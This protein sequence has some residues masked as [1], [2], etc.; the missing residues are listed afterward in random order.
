[1]GVEPDH[2]EPRGDSLRRIARVL[3]AY[4]QDDGTYAVFMDLCS[5]YQKGL[6]GEERTPLELTLFRQALRSLSTWSAHQHTIVPVTMR[7]DGTWIAA[8]TVASSC[9]DG[10]SRRDAG[11]S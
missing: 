1:M 11:G 4:A 3:S 10:S 6:A 5:L 9:M 7:P 8:Q 2:P